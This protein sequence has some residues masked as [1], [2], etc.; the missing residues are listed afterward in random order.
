MIKELDSLHWGVVRSSFLT[1]PCWEYGVPAG[2]CFPPHQTELPPQHA[3]IQAM[4]PA[5]VQLPSPHSLGEIGKI[6]SDLPLPHPSLLALNLKMDLLA[7][8]MSMPVA[9][10]TRLFFEN[11]TRVTK[12]PWCLLQ[13]GDIRYLWNIGQKNISQLPLSARSNNLYYWRK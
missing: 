3:A 4:A 5:T 13:S 2:Q 7:Q 11:W 9:G 6:L 1:E 10:R 12:D 8:H